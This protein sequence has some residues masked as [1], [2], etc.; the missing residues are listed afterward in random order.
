MSEKKNETRLT[1]HE[2][3]VLVVHARVQEDRSWTPA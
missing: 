1:E 3:L 2:E